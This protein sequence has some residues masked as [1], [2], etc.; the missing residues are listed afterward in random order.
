MRHGNNTSKQYFLMYIEFID[1]SINRFLLLVI[2]W[3]C[4]IKLLLKRKKLDG[5]IYILLD[6]YLIFVSFGQIAKISRFIFALRDD[7]LVE[8]IAGYT[9]AMMGSLSPP[10][11]KDILYIICDVYNC[12]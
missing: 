9:V 6:L 11:C 10:K 2:P 1:Y 8:F 3:D 5:V 4:Y 7:T 12:V